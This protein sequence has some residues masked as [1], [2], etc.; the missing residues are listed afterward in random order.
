[1]GNEIS[2]GDKFIYAGRELQVTYVYEGGE[3]VDAVDGDG[4][5]LHNLRVED[6]DEWI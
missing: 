6:I 2:I 5:E 3:E 1:L 4:Q